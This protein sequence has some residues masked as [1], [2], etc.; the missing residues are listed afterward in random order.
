MA[1]NVFELI[2]VIVFSAIFH[3]FSFFYFFSPL[4][5]I[6]IKKHYSQLQQEQ[7]ERGGVG[8]TQGT[9]SQLLPGVGG[10]D[11]LGRGLSGGDA[12]KGCLP[13]FFLFLILI[14]L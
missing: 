10:H 5:N 12:G 2:Y 11:R 3:A 7:K 13:S 8:K 4:K 9:P 6:F 14:S 1:I